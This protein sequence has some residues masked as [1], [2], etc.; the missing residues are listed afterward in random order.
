MI[1]MVA[2]WKDELSIRQ[3]AN[4]CS[5]RSPMPTDVVLVTDQNIV[6]R[7][8]WRLVRDGHPMILF[9]GLTCEA[10]RNEVFEIMK[11]REACGN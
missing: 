3:Y 7:V 11:E 6:L 10:T 1:T 8:L 4:L 2:T 5:H 9:C